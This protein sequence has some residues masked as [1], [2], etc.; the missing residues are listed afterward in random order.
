MTEARYELVVDADTERVTVLL[1]GRKLENRDAR[2]VLMVALAYL[3]RCMRATNARP[4]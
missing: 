1:D 4:A 3:D 2:G